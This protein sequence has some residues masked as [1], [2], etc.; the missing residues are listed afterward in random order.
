M[1]TAHAVRCVMSAINVTFD[2][3]GFQFTDD[4]LVFAQAFLNMTGSGDI[5]VIALDYNVDV[6]ASLHDTKQRRPTF[7]PI[8]WE[9]MEGKG[10]TFKP[11]GS[12]PKVF[13]ANSGQGTRW[14]HGDL[15]AY[16]LRS[17]ILAMPAPCNQDAASWMLQ[18]EKGHVLHQLE[19]E[20]QQRLLKLINQQ[21]QQLLQHSQQHLKQQQHML[22]QLKKLI[23]STAG[24]DTQAEL[25]VATSLPSSRGKSHLLLLRES[26]WGNHKLQPVMPPAAVIWQQMLAAVG[27]T[28]VAAVASVQLRRRRRVTVQSKH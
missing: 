16:A 25:I 28:V 5:P 18:L 8:D 3:H 20:Q 1:G 13:H 11:T 10:W 23:N 21:Q 26:A 12:V 19:Q 6:F 2:D 15:L 9:C 7:K 22:Q 17:G 24:N 4:Q 27:I 14:L